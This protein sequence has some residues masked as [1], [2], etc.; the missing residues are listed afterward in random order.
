MLFRTPLKW[1]IS[2][3]REELLMLLRLVAQRSSPKLVRLIY[4][5]RKDLEAAFSSFAD[6]RAQVGAA[7]IRRRS[8]LIAP[9]PAVRLTP[10]VLHQ[11]SCGCL[12][13][14]P[15]TR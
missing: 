4:E 5:M 12:L 9:S 7:D 3:V 14:L 13:I 11:D 8:F 10:R 2:G 1:P 15:V 6:I